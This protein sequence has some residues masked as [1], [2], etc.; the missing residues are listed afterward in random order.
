MKSSTYKY[1]LYFLI[2][3]RAETSETIRKKVFLFLKNSFKNILKRN[4][5]IDYYH[6]TLTIYVI[7][8]FTQLY[9]SHITSII[10]EYRKNTCKFCEF[11]KEGL[12][13]Y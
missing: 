6:L 11:L 10:K 4:F 2:R 13:I 8:K 7:I 9:I 3:D 1:W 12:I 5:E